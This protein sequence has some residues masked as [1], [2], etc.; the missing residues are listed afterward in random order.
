VLAITDPNEELAADKANFLT[1]HPSFLDHSKSL[2]GD[3]A[4]F[5]FCVNRRRLHCPTIRQRNTY[6]I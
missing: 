2:S 1:L 3:F 5:P 6:I 4:I